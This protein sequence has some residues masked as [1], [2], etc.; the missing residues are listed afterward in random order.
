MELRDLMIFAACVLLVA[1]SMMLLVKLADDNSWRFSEM[2]YDKDKRGQRMKLEEAVGC[3]MLIC[4]LVALA[5]TVI[6]AVAAVIGLI[7]Y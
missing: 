1:L 4:F 5:M 6:F 7:L 3:L 2:G